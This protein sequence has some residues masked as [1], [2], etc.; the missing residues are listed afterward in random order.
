[1]DELAKMAAMKM[2]KL[3]VSVSGAV[4]AFWVTYGVRKEWKRKKHM[5]SFEKRDETNEFHIQ[6][7]DLVIDLRAVT[8]ASRVTIWK[9]SN[10]EK[11]LDGESFEKVS[12]MHE[13]TDG[14]VTPIMPLFKFVPLDTRMRKLIARIAKE[15]E[16]LFMETAKEED[17]E[18]KLMANLYAIKTQYHFKLGLSPF[19]GIVTVAG[20]NRDVFIDEPT[21]N[22]VRIYIEKIRILNKKI[23][24]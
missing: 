3:I 10:G 16:Y 22:K 2:A 9:Y 23:V 18:Q 19:E 1:M 7:R 4:F 6:M 5:E 20:V 21:M 14:N 8:D 24:S 13:K 12:C 15:K 17:P 11:F